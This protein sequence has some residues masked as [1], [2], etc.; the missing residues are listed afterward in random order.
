M[1]YPL[2]ILENM[3]HPDDYHNPEDLGKIAKL[4]AVVKKLE[5]LVAKE[6]SIQEQPAKKRTKTKRSKKSSVGRT[7]K[8]DI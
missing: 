5:A 8:S 1:S 2:S 3:L 4:E 6:I 7:E